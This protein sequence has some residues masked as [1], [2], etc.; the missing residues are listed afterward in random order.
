MRKIRQLATRKNLSKVKR[1]IAQGQWK[2]LIKGVWRKLRSSEKKTE[3]AYEYAQILKNHLRR[4]GALESSLLGVSVDIIVPVYNGKELVTRMLDGVD[5]TSVAH[6]LILIDDASP[7]EETAEYLR[8]YAAQ[9]EHVELIRN[10]QN[11]GFVGSV[12]RGLAM[13]RNHVVILNTDVELPDK[14]LE[15]LISPVVKDPTVASATPFTNSGTICS[16]PVFME[17]NHIFHHLPVDQIDSFF[18][19]IRPLYT[20]IPTGV[21]FCMA[22]SKQAIHEVGLLDQKVFGRGY[23]EEND[24]CQRA[25]KMGFRNVMV[26]NLYVVHNHGGTFTSNEKRRL[27][28]ENREKLADRHPDYANQVGEYQK[29]DPMGPIRA[30][31]ACRLTEKLSTKRYLVF[32]NTLG[33]GADAYIRQYTAKRLIEGAA[34]ALVRYLRPEQ[35]YQIE[36][37]WKQLICRFSCHTLE[38]VLNFA[39][40]MDMDQLIV[41]QL[42]TYPDLPTHLTRIREFAEQRGMRLMFMAHDYYLICPSIYLLNDRYEFCH[43]PHISECDHCLQR[44]AYCDNYDMKSMREWRSMWRT[45]L[46]SCHEVRVFSQ[47]SAQLIKKAY[48]GLDQIQVLPV[49]H[50]P[51]S[52]VEKPYKTTDTLNIGLLGTLTDLKGARLVREMAHIID[53]RHFP[54]RLI[55]CGAAADPIR[56]HCLRQTGPYRPEM[57]PRMVLENDIDLFFIA[58][59]CPETFSYTT[60]EAMEMG[61]PTACLPLGAPMERLIR[62][63]RG[64]IL[65]E[66]QADINLKEL[67]DF[68]ESVCAERKKAEKALFVIEEE[69]YASRYRVDHLREQ[70]LRYGIQSECMETA[71]VPLSQVGRYKWLI[72]YRCELTARIRRVIRTANESGA[73]IWYSTDDMVFDYEAVRGLDFVRQTEYRN[74]EERCRRNYECMRECD[75]VLVSTETL[76]QEVLKRFPGKSVL[77][78]RNAASYEM[79]A[80]SQKELQMKRMEKEEILLGYFSGSSTHNADF[81]LIEPVLLDLLKTHPEVRL[82]IVGVLELSNEFD[83]VQ[84]QIE[85]MPF[86]PWT[87]LPGL[88]AEVDINLMPLQ[89]TVFHACKSENKWLEASLVKTP[90]I[91]SYN[92]ELARVIQAGET[93]I[94][95]RNRQEW[96]ETLHT[97]VEDPEARK[98]IGTKAYEAAI[99]Q[100][101]KQLEPEIR[102]IFGC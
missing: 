5:K 58:S 27:M 14:W 33:G 60:Q 12:N 72:L 68:G 35:Q 71:Q 86:L 85:R 6:R 55:L 8:S 15:R 49:Q 26:E 88:L 56:S 47:D 23:G 2:P 44:N 82:R 50:T 94:L 70:L 96:T 53:N 1:L 90:T 16:F 10:A 30:Y 20:T 62:Y 67:R 101:T 42:V 25:V 59:V 17:D 46:Q 77:L 54:V 97:L 89:S 51:L 99:Q 76:R 95:C 78:H 40:R 79:V 87:Q 24:W 19:E 63:S 13:S 34:V 69:S 41:N 52:I 39:E 80:L 84:K 74:F 22:M 43:I 11:L 75:G 18:R 81:S 102:E 57:L 28:Q 93:G 45:F 98:A 64:K 37:H 36:Y 73:S 32:H 61:V 4:E 29:R 3:K 92:A 83:A 100:T 31:V 9:H 65:S 66:P 91:A 7:D 48:G 21:G 38:E